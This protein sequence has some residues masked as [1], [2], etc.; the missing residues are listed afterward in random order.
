MHIMAR[1]LALC[2]LLFAVLGSCGQ[3]TP[4]IDLGEVE[5]AHCRMN[6]SD[7]RF[8]AVIM[9]T[10]GRQYS[11]DGPECM[12]SFVTQ[13]SLPEAEV[14][15][16]YVSDFEHPSVLLD[17]TKALYVHGPAFRSPMRGDV[18]AFASKVDRDK[19][20]KDLGGDPMDWPDARKQ[21]AR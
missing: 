3:Q 6:V 12:V 7:P 17:A 5:C 8:A 2:A 19:A 4:H 16:W 11:F 18:A 15:Q 14:A 10:K 21:L 1:S 20:V 13:G 9:T